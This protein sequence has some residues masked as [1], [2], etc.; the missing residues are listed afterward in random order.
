MPQRNLLAT[1]LHV[2]A[3]LALCNLDF[4][5]MMVPFY[6]FSEKRPGMGFSEERNPRVYIFANSKILMVPIVVFTCKD[7]FV[8]ELIE[9]RVLLRSAREMINCSCVI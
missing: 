4:F 8:V 9:T 3:E 1:F 6:E 7:S 5:A 2:H